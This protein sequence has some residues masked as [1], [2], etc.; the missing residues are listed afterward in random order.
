MVQSAVGAWR[1]V[2][3]AR[4]GVAVGAKGAVRVVEV[5][6][7]A[8]QKADGV[9]VGRVTARVVLVPPKGLSV[10]V[11]RY[12]VVSE[13]RPLPAQVRLM[14]AGVGYLPLRGV[15]RVVRSAQGIAE[16]PNVRARVKTAQRLTRRQGSVTA[17]RQARLK[18]VAV[19]AVDRRR[20]CAVALPVVVVLQVAARAVAWVVKPALTPNRLDRNRQTRVVREIR[21]AVQKP[22]VYGLAIRVAVMRGLLSGRE[23]AAQTRAKTA[24]PHT[25]VGKTCRRRRAQNPARPRQRPVVAQKTRGGQTRPLRRRLGRAQA[26]RRQSDTARLKP[27]ADK[28]QIPEPLKLR[29]HVRRSRRRVPVPLPGLKLRTVV[30]GSATERQKPAKRPVF[31][32]C[33]KLRRAPPP[34]R[35]QVTAL[36]PQKPERVVVELKFDEQ[37][38][39]PPTAKA[40]VVPALR[41]EF[42]GRHARL[43]RAAVVLMVRLGVAP[44]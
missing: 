39:L 20:V 18:Q 21:A 27:H 41:A 15:P 36:H 16:R 6:Q 7:I 5:R 2:A 14:A 23:A 37:M 25:A 10:L 19:G 40:D 44:A 3:G 35:R 24:R 22:L 12:R 1:S 32:A 11:A 43:G 29:L 17:A 34:Q 13:K 8:A 26:D 42:A 9:A 38:A 30:A 31:S 28:R 4:Y 33:E